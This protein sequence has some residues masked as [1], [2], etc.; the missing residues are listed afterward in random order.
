MGSQSGSGNRFR[1]LSTRSLALDSL[2]AEGTAWKLKLDLTFGLSLPY[3]NL[4][5]GLGGWVT[6]NGEK[7][8]VSLLSKIQL[9]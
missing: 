3:G 7:K 4:G 9:N 1:F 5:E 6:G 2:V 8:A